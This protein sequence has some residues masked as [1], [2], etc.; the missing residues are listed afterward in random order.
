MNKADRRK[1]Q[2]QLEED[3]RNAGADRAREERHKP[4]VWPCPAATGRNHSFARTGDRRCVY[5]HKTPTE[6]RTR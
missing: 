3:A 1:Y 5:C 2:Q 6:A 4:I